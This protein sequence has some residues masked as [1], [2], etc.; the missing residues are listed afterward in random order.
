MTTPDNSPEKVTAQLSKLFMSRGASE[1]QASTM[2]KQLQK[3]SEQLAVQRNISRVE[4][5]QELLT[6]ILKAQNDHD[7]PRPPS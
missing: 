7:M 5:M 6:L 3:R 2:A 4:A 1:E